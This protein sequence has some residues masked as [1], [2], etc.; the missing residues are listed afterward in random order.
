VIDQATAADAMAVDG[1]VVAF[2]PAVETIYEIASFDALGWIIQTTIST[3]GALQRMFLEYLRTTK[4]TFPRN[5]KVLDFVEHPQ[6]REDL[7]KNTYFH[8]GLMWLLIKLMRV[9]IVT[10]DPKELVRTLHKARI[11]SMGHGLVQ[12][13]AGL[14]TLD[15][16]QYKYLESMKQVATFLHALY[17]RAWP[18]GLEALNVKRYASEDCLRSKLCAMSKRIFATNGVTVQADAPDC[19]TAVLVYPY[20]PTIRPMQM[21]FENLDG[22][23]VLGSEDSDMNYVLFVGFLSAALTQTHSHL[24]TAITCPEV[25]STDQDS[26]E[27]G[28]PTL[29]LIQT[30][31]LDWIRTTPWAPTELDLKDDIKRYRKMQRKCDEVLELH[32][33]QRFLQTMEAAR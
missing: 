22:T 11:W 13:L 19:G 17:L 29:S 3:S 32:E 18:T 9:S 31:L 23:K 25:W 16:K 28:L 5:I 6:N 30:R 4:C 14:Q 10:A 26:L 24:V 27:T 33:M 20:G 21:G 12:S 8:L 2:K 15:K 1:A 7:W